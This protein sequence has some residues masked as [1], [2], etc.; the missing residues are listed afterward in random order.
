MPYISQ[1]G[2]GLHNRRCGAGGPLR[3][4]GPDRLRSPIEGYMGKGGP[5]FHR[6]PL[7]LAGM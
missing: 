6:V 3:I 5:D 4:L 7:S 2:R 1:R